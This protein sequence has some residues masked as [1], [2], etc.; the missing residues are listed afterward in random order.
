MLYLTCPHKNVIYVSIE[1]SIDA[2]NPLARRKFA[3]GS[4]CIECKKA[5]KLLEL[6]KGKF[7]NQSGT[8]TPQSTP[9]KATEYTYPSS[10][11]Q[12]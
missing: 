9:V 3:V 5:Q 10:G 6:K 4:Q 7:K 11:K 2:S 12:K 8:K 1:V